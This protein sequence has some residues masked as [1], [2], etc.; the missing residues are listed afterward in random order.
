MSRHENGA[1]APGR[2]AH[3]RAGACA[4]HVVEHSRYESWENNAS[5]T[6]VSSTPVRRQ[7]TST[8]EDGAA[9]VKVV[10]VSGAN[11]KRRFEQAATG[12]CWLT[13]Y[14]MLQC[15]HVCYRRR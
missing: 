7:S 10:A 1:F 9:M 3:G 2:T 12:A 14:S 15:T 8:E 5:W 13:A 11:R 4:L 6:A